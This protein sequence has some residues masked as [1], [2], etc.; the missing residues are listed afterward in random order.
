[1]ANTPY[2]DNHGGTDVAPPPA[3]TKLIWR[4][5]IILCVITAFEFL[6]AFTMTAGPLRVFIFVGMTIIKAFYIVAEFMHLKH[7]VKSLIWAIMLPIIF[8]I[9]LLIALMYEGGSIFQLR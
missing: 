6:I 1:M 5:F 3:N 2:T 7:E 8:I 4:T 9:W